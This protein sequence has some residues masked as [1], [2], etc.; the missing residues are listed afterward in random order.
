MGLVLVVPGEEFQ[1]NAYILGIMAE[2]SFQIGSLTL[3]HPFVAAPMAGVSDLAF[4]L[5]C[6]R[7]GASLAFTEMVSARGLVRNGSKTHEFIASTPEERPLGVQLFGADPVE[8]G[9]AAAR[10][11][12]EGL[13][14]LVDVNMGC[15]VRKVVKTGAGSALLCEPNKVGAI[16]AGI[17][18][19]TK[20]PVMIKIRAGW[21]STTINAPDVARIA[22]S[23]GANA[24]TLHARTREQGY[25]GLADWDLVRMTQEAVRI[26]IIGSGDVVTPHQ[27]VERARSHPNGLVMIGRGATGKPWIFRQ[28]LALYKG[29]PI[30]V[31]P[32]AERLATLHEHFRLYVAQHGEWRAVREFRKHL[33]WY[34][35]GTRGAREM[36]G[37]V[38]KLLTVADVEAMIEL[39]GAR[40][41]EA[42]PPEAHEITGDAEEQAYWEER[43]WG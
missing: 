40:W 15:P 22:E 11:E 33:L 17:R 28:I 42:L 34:A 36:R 32:A 7:E 24:V 3:D 19:R 10:L 21:D 8:L 16:V 43:G 37:G 38:A 18:R 29:L 35:K 30:P 4:R 31:V 5:L 9:E 26:P 1:Y 23:E 14:D 39:L 25:T 2:K 12:G 6:R 13:A 27:A 20:L 41:H